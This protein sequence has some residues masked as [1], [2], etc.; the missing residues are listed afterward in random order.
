MYRIGLYLFLL[1]G[2]HFSS[3]AQALRTVAA[4]SDELKENS[5]MVHYGGGVL[6][7]INDGGNAPKLHRYDTATDTYSHFDILNADNV[8]WEDLATD[9]ERN[10]YIGDCGNNTNSRKNLRIYKS[11]NPEAIITNQLVVDTVSF[12]Y[13]NQSSFH[14]T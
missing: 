12:S 6:F 4:L 11:V 14:P 9:D 2:V 13:D 10:I 8:D 5:G 1:V 3:S 7:F